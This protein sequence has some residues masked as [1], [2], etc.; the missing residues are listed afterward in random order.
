M[1]E[2]RIARAYTRVVMNR[3][4]ESIK[5]ATAYRISLDLDGGTNDWLVQH[6]PRSKKIVW[7]QHQFRVMVDVEAEKF[8]CECKQWEHTGMDVFWY[9]VI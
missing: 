1:F 2:I 6:T 8:Q 9:Y 7:G 3:F 5:Y 4:D